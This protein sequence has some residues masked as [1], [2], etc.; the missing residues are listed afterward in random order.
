[1]LRREPP[2]GP[3][4]RRRR[5][6]PLRDAAVAMVETADTGQGDHTA[7]VSFFDRSRNRCV[8]LQGHVSAVLV[9]VRQVLR[10]N[11]AEVG[12]AQDDDVVQALS[13][14]GANHALGVGILPGGLR[15]KEHG[16][17]FHDGQYRAPAS[18]GA[19]EQGIVARNDVRPEGPR[20]AAGSGPVRRPRQLRIVLCSAEYH[21]VYLK[22]CGRSAHSDAGLEQRP[23]RLAFGGTA[24]RSRY[25]RIALRRRLIILP[26]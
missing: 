25:R 6:R 19:G 10:Q 14:Y 2:R 26:R 12:F 9:V 13:T 8:T 4:Q 11:P 17:R 3:R 20:A 1:M 23:K 15:C 21:R 7:G 5:E 18:P 24:S 16:L 22:F